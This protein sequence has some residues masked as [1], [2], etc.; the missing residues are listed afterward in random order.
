V[1]DIGSAREKTS[2]L[3]RQHI[4]PMLSPDNALNDDELVAFVA[5][6]ENSVGFFPVMVSEWK[7]DGL[8]WRLNEHRQ[9]LEAIEGW[10]KRSVELLLN[11][12]EQR[13]SVP[14]HRSFY[15]ISWYS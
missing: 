13:R 4:V 3:P 14:L 8:L 2:F 6:V 1:R 12:L 15:H 10:G 11:S 5:H 7:V 9:A